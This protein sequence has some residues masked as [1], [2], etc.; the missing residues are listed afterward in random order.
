VKKNEKV[1]KIQSA[2]SPD[3]ADYEDKLQKAY[4]VIALRYELAEDVVRQVCIEE[5]KKK[6]PPE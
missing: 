6:W 2:L 3:D 5:A 1:W 4:G